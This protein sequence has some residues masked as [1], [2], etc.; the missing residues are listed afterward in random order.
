MYIS[1]FKNPRDKT[2]MIQF[3]KQFSAYDIRWVVDA[4]NSCTK[5][6]YTYMVGVIKKC[7]TTPID[8]LFFQTAIRF[9]ADD[10]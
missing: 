2:V 5:A 8:S 4:Y 10:P 1:I 9:D 3:A 7:V 6:P